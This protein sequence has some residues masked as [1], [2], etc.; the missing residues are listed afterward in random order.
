LSGLT[1][2]GGP[3]GRAGGGSGYF[4]ALRLVGDPVDVVTG[5]ET[6]FE[7]DFRLPGAPVPLSWVRHYDSRR[8]NVDRG[9]GPGFRLNLDVELQMDVD[10]MTF[11][12]GRGIEI[13]FPYPVEDGQRI[14]RHAHV[15]ERLSLTRH[16]VHRPKDAASFEFEFARDRQT[17]AR[18]TRLIGNHG[19]GPTVRFVYD[20]SGLSLIDLGNQG[21]LAIERE[22]GRVAG[23]VLISA[24]GKRH[25]L[26]RYGY[27]ISGRLIEAVNGYGHAI[28]YEYDLGGRVARKI[29]RRGY[30]FY[31]SYDSEGR[32]IHTRGEDGVAEC[33][34]EYRPHERLTLVTRGDGGV[35]RYFYDED[36]SIVQIID[37]Y[38]GLTAFLKDETGKVIGEIDPNGNESE[39]I[40][41]SLGLPFANRDPLGHLRRLPLGSTPHPLSHDLPV[42]PCDWEQGRQSLLGFARPHPGIDR[43]LPSWVVDAVGATPDVALLPTTVVSDV[44]GVPL[45]EE[46]ADGKVRRWGL[47]PNGYQRW[48][49]DFDGHTVRFEY[50]S[51]NH[52]A[53]TETPVKRVTQ[54]EYT[55]TEKFAAVTDPLGARTEYGY[56]LKERLVEVRRNGKVR[57]RCRYDSADNLVEKLD[58]DGVPILKLTIG[59]GNVLRQRQLGTGDLQDFG[60]DKHGR[61]LVAKNRAGVCE[62]SYDST[63]RQVSDERDGVGV[64]HERKDPNLHRTTVLGR[65]TTECISLE[66]GVTTLVRDPA[67]QTQR[68][69]RIGPG[70]FERSCSNGVRELALYDLKG[71]CLLKAA[72]GAFLKGGGWARRFSYSGEGSLVRRED[73]AQGASEYRYDEG[74]RLSGAELA[75]GSE[76]SYVYDRADN[77]LRAPGLVAAI[78]LGNKLLSANGD[79]FEYDKRDNMTRRS[80]S[81]GDDV[82]YSYD[83]RDQ[84]VAID[85]PGL[86]YRAEHDALGRRTTKTVNGE[87][88]K[89][90]WDEDRLAGE[91]FPDGKL[92]IYVYPSAEALVPILFVDYDSVDA[93]SKTGRRFHLFT[94]H[95]GCP[96]LVLDDLGRTVWRAR[97]QPYGTALVEVGADFHQPLRWPG[98][99]FD[100]ETGLH[101]NRFR[102][103]SPELGRYL[104]SDPI[105]LRGGT[106]LYAY[107]ENPLRA[108]DLN[109]LATK[110][111]TDPENC[112][113]KKKEGEDQEGTP[114]EQ[115]GKKQPMSDA[116]LQAAADLIHESIGDEKAQKNRTTTIT[117]LE[118]GRLAVTVSGRVTKDQEGRDR[119]T[120]LTGDQRA[121][122]K[123]LLGPDVLMPDQPGNP[124]HVPVAQRPL[125]DPT[126]ER[127]DTAH[128]GEGKGVQAA[129]QQG[130]APVRQVSS[131]SAD[132]GGAAC[133]GC[134]QLQSDRGIANPTGTQ[135][136]GGRTDGG[137]AA[138]P[139]A[140]D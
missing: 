80:G 36:G 31:F 78:Q 75:D 121:A 40:H 11:V 17:D 23:A 81:A 127:G 132:H 46:R 119:I 55:P 134:A 61:I 3:C 20:K 14:L 74:G 115:Q 108:V 72:E 60:R 5:A 9:V 106:N 68:L 109:G 91:L 126:G 12:D 76:Q 117:E 84:L 129:D 98:H 67:D 28:R 87:T 63:G 27:D 7:T 33:R 100:I 79:R 105:G 131:S 37:P 135:S 59:P 39:I 45:R 25:Q 92:R 6:H 99:Y 122:A 34:L 65:Y 15:L 49:T 22:R 102:S 113:L 101:E 111:E 10:G 118:D 57:E 82:R 32:C 139:A 58:A 120:T 89:Y 125:S 112:P 2:G 66:D 18:L 138:V 48:H 64:R 54:Y 90:Y 123:A 19:R 47:D 26:L 85:Q 128:H 94:S 103:Y 140:D 70:L 137:K 50:A 95:L 13:G 124:A 96:E 35:W 130:S 71:R 77:L 24:D 133:D 1:R 62:F 136:Q 30:S 93:D 69:R 107:T 97:I 8:P 51:W 83:S 44:Q 42:S 73:S 21:R 16:V 4:E 116:D 43:L 104:Q 41:D 88:W 52:L 38:G 53:M 56:D 29:D 110:C 114:E 86:V